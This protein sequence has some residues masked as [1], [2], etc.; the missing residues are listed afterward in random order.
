MRDRTENQVALVMIRHGAAKS[1][2][3]HRYLG[4]TEE[5]LCEEGIE[6]L[7]QY[8]EQGC[9]PK[10]DRLFVSPMVRCLQTA[11]ILYP[12][13]TPICIDEWRE[14]DFGAFEGKNHRELQEDV[15]YQKWIDSGGTL[16]FPQGENRE[17]FMRR[18]VLGFEKMLG[19]IVEWERNREQESVGMV[20]HGG[21]IMSL[22]SRYCG[23]DYFDYQTANGRGF[24][25]NCRWGNGGTQLTEAE[26]L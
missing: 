7:M 23:G 15:R 14:I 11:E 16:P 21:T 25:C 22:L 4:T 17:A 12:T 2:W 24:R 9:Y 3:E 6:E 1:N 20:V 13:L 18:C 5:P 8:R 19:Q 26:K 10:I